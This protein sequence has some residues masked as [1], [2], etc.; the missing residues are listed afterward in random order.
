M[1][2]MLTSKRIAFPALF[3]PKNF[4]G[5]GEEKFQVTT[6]IP[7]NDPQ[8][9]EIN[10]AIEKVAKEKWGAKA[11]GILKTLRAGGK[12]CFKDGAEKSNYEG[13]EGCW[14][15]AANNTS[16]PLILDRNKAA[17]AKG[18]GKPYAGCYCNVNI[19]IYAQDNAWGKRINASLRGVQFVKDGDSFGGGAPASA[20]EFDSVDEGADAES[21]V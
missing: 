9:A 14:F 15:I 13:F 20:D 3:D 7:E 10:A 17:L 8:M 19:E 11:E 4:N 1:K 21:L 16:R 6:L 5:E 2:L 18:D 12:I